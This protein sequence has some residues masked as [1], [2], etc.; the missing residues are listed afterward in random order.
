M[1]Q[2]PVWIKILVSFPLKGLTTQKQLYKKLDVSNLLVQLRA[3]DKHNLITTARL[4]GRTNG[5]SLTPLG[6]E[7]SKSLRKLFQQ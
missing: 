1:L 4:D 5:Y 2:Q 3:L 7:V 6:K